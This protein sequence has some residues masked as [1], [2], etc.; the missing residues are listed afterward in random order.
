MLDEQCGVSPRHP[1]VALEPFYKGEN[2]LGG[3]YFGTSHLMTTHGDTSYVAAKLRFASETPGP[4]SYEVAA[5]KNRIRGGVI[6]RT[7]R[8]VDF[9]TAATIRYPKDRDG[10][11]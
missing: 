11:A 3:N 7:G 1:G 9:D 4:G 10:V 2:T 8:D 5:Q 6:V